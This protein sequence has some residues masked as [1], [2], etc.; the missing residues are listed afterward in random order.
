MASA[1]ATGHSGH[2]QKGIREL[3]SAH[4]PGLQSSLGQA[5]M[6]SLKGFPYL[7]EPFTPHP[8]HSMFQITRLRT[9]GSSKSP[10]SPRTHLC[11]S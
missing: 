9:Q 6:S 1:R 4:S 7:G 5:A 11:T 8:R 2:S 3:M 10:R